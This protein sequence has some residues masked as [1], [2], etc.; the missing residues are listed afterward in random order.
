MSVK[1]LTVEDYLEKLPNERKEVLHKIRQILLSNLPNGFQEEMNY[2]LPSFVVPKKL[3]PPGYHVNP[4]ISLPFISLASQKNHIGF[5]HLGLYANPSLLQWFTRA[6]SN[7]VKHKLD[8]GKS[9]IRFKKMDTIPYVLL[10]ELAQKMTPEE[11]ISIY[12]KHLKP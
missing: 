11:W 2:G 5:Y 10:R 4:K 12:E 3:Y 1:I 7:T 6:Y 9:C 8:M